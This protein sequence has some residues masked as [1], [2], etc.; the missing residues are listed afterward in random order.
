[1]SSSQVYYKVI[2]NV[3]TDVDKWS[4]QNIWKLNWY[5]IPVLEVFYTVILNNDM[6]QNKKNN[7]EIS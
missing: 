7:T 3:Y 2:I 5:Y 4:L 6:I 1:M